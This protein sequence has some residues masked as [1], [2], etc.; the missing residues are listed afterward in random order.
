MGSIFDLGVDDVIIMIMMDI[1]KMEGISAVHWVESNRIVLANG[2][3]YTFEQR[4]YLIGPL[5]SVSRLKCVRK[6]RGLGFSETLILWSIHGTSQG[7]YR[8]GVQYVFPTETAMR[9]FVQSRFNVVLRRNAWLR[10]I[11]RDTDTTYFKRVGES[12]LFMNG[13]VLTTNIEGLQKETMTFRSKQVDCAV[14]DELDMFD[15]ANDVVGSALTSMKNSP[16]K[17]VIAISNPSIPNYGIDRLFQGSNQN[18]WYRQCKSGCGTLTCP[19]KE[20][21]DLIDKGGCHC[22]KCG[23]NLVYRGRWI[24]DRPERGSL[25]GIRSQD[26][27]GY[28]ISD[29]NAPNDDPYSILDQYRDKSEANL[30]K[31]YKFSLGLPFMPKTSSLSLTEVYDCCG[32]KPEYDRFEG[33]AAMGV[34]VGG[35]SGF[36][37]VIGYRTG[38]DSYEVVRTDCL[39]SF[40]DVVLLGYKFGVK[41]CVCDMLPEVTGARRFQKNSGLRVWLCLYPAAAIPLE[42]AV[43]DEERRL[44]KVSRNFICDTSHRIIA[45]NKV[46]L[47]RRS[48]KLEEFAKQYIVPVKI[49]GK[50]NLFKYESFGRDDHFRHAMNY[51]LLAS[52]RTAARTLTVRS[53][54]L[55]VTQTDTQRY[56]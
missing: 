50:N 49:K 34:D 28:H 3:T 20:F 25:T 55:T 41:S 24:P 47:P 40:E 32:I 22:V 14:I 56:I 42:E 33:P 46:I 35:S 6:A 23:S 1:S 43:W 31:L 26:W 52:K 16:T 45:E 2:D 44:V 29:L 54:L 48:R 39:E 37:V 7:V 11:V 4:P 19:D 10:A 8:Q 5:S 27:E 12:N 13:G 17:S 21:P 9:E 15:D 51:F 30:E 36:Y 38:R 18:Y 53:G